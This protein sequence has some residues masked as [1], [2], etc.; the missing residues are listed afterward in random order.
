[1]A[2]TDSKVDVYIEKAGEF[3]RPIL[4]HLRNLVHTACPDVKET[5]KWGFPHFEYKGMLCHM[6]AFKKHCSFGFWKAALINES[7][8]FLN[9]L[10]LQGIDHFDRISTMQDLP[11]DSV[12]ISYIKE[13]MRLNEDEIKM[14]KK[15][16]DTN[17]LAVS[18]PDAFKKALDA[19][20]KANQVFEKASPSFR[21]E[22]IEWIAD[23]KT[24]LTRDKRIATALEWISEGKG[25]NWKYER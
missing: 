25:R 2:V 10:G 9:S 19:D 4:I 8:Q 23:A 3:A 24:D 7:A 11:A 22:Y 16:I 6:A 13:A 17:R 1:M 21:K 14:P 15:K 20:A 5:I 18:I 12:L